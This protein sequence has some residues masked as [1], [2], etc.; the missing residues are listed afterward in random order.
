MSQI[1]LSF[2]YGTLKS[3]HYNHV[4]M[5]RAGGKLVGEASIKG[6]TMYS[7]GG[8]PG[9]VLDGCDNT[10]Y[11]E[12]FEVQDFAPLDRLEGYPSFYDRKIVET[13]IGK[14]WVYFLRPEQVRG[15]PV[16][17]SGVW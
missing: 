8:F 5:E 14:A 2:C 6:A 11:G 10:I 13:S 17:E 1:N 4:V 15:L 12:V 7:L 16:V 3:G 9:I